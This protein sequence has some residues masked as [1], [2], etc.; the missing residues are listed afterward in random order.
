MNIRVVVIDDCLICQ[1]CLYSKHGSD[2]FYLCAANNNREILSIHKKQKTLEIP[3]WC[4]RPTPEQFKE[5]TP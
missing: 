1:E 5:A 2:Y 4:E 3:D